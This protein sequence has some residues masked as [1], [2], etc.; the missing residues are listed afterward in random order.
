[1]NKILE[2]LHRSILFS[3]KYHLENMQIFYEALALHKSFIPIVHVAGTNGK[4]SVCT[5]IDY[6]V[7]RSGYKT[8]LFTSPHIH[9][10]CERIKIKG[11]DVSI[12]QLTE[13]LEKIYLI[14]EE[15]KINLSFFELLTLTALLIFNQERVELIILE[16]GLGGRLDATNVISP[17]LS[18]I[19]S[20]GLDHCHILGS[21]IEQIAK[22][23]AGIIKSNVPLVLGP[24]ANLPD[25]IAIAKQKKAEI[26]CV[27]NSDHP[28]YD[29]EN[30]DIAKAAL[31]QLKGFHIT[32]RDVTIR[33]RGRWQ[34]ACY[35]GIDLLFD[36]SHNVSG[37]KKLLQGIKKIFPGQKIHMLFAASKDK[38]LDQ[39]FPL[40]K[41]IDNL[42][43][44]S[45]NH[46]RLCSLDLLQQKAKKYQLSFHACHSI[47]DAKGKILSMTKREKSLIVYTGSFYLLQDVEEAFNQKR[48]GVSSL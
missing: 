23:K 24:T 14:E 32:E 1:M 3:K 17:M 13:A 37:I 16:V 5:K 39:I 4:G 8:G 22:E 29:K 11:K 10:L 26:H 31:A 48:M 28:F 19:T 47:E 43:L 21:T 44:L 15:K 46:S 18:V 27:Q 7:H 41:E 9:S 6:A 30:Q 34:K 20:I 42:Y 12:D 45:G 33:P 38:D 35:E 25:I 40:L 2:K 36:L